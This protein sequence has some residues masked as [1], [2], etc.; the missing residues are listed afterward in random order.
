MTGIT[1]D[2]LESGESRAGVRLVA[3]DLYTVTAEPEPR[4]AFQRAWRRAREVVL[5]PPLASR[6]QRAERL[7]IFA[8]IALIGSDMIASS[9]YGPEEM[10]L[11]LGE[12]GPGGVAFAFPLTVAIGLLL[13][14]LAISYLQTIKAY[15]NGA[16]GYIVAKDNF[17]PLLGVIGAAA[18]LIDYTLDVAVSIATG[19]QSITSAL[20]D[21]GWALVWLCLA[22]LGIYTL[23][24]LRC[25]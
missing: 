9:V 18:L 25:S 21:V 1:E 17:G 7:S 10:I 23:A 24:N 2:R 6:L 16:G 19:V 15:P 12:A 22:A 11:R 3:P 20:P 14:V 13:A 5:G 8:A 4:G